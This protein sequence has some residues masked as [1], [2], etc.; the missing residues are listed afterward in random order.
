M[1][2]E[3]L[4]QKVAVRFLDGTSVREGVLEELDGQFVKY[5][6]EYQLLYIPI[7]SIRAV[8]LETKERERPRV[9]FGQ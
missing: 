1:L 8:A 6:S 5:R 9:G 3:L 7:S 4:G 2:Q